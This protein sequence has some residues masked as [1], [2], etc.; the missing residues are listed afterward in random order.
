MVIGKAAIVEFETYCDRCQY[1]DC[2][3]ADYKNPCYL[4]LAT[5]ARYDRS[6]KPINFREKG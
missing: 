2:D 6:K 3:D 1:K 5:P 4:C